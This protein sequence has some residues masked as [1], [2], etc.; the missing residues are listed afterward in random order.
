MEE[1]EEKKKKNRDWD[2]EALQLAGFTIQC[3]IL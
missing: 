3:Y 1:K 2:K